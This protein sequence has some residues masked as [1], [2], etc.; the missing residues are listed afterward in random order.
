M[1]PLCHNEHLSSKSTNIKVS[2][3]LNEHLK[4]IP[5]YL[6][7]DAASSDDIG[8]TWAELEAEDVIGALQHQLKSTPPIK[9]KG[10]KWYWNGQKSDFVAVYRQH[11]SEAVFRVRPLGWKVLLLNFTMDIGSTYETGGLSQ[12]LGPSITT[13]GLHNYWGHAVLC[14]TEEYEVGVSEEWRR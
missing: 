7:I 5:K 8:V 11:T 14:E 4:T 6:S 3:S 13:Q 10:I 12:D 9:K 1:T 2:S